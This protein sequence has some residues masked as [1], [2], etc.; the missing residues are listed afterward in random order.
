MPAC[1]RPGRELSMGRRS[2]ITHPVKGG[3]R[4][5]DAV[6]PRAI[7]L[8]G[9]I[10]FILSCGA[11]LPAIGAGF[12]D[13]DD[14]GFL[15][16]ATG[17]R[18]L[19]PE[20]LAWMATAMR[21]G[22]YQ[23]L[24]YLSYAIDYTFWGMDPR[25]YHT[26]NI[27][28]HAGNA[29]LLMFVLVRVLIL[30]GAERSRSLLFAAAAASI[31]WAVH[32]LRVESVA[33]I[34]ERRDVLSASFLL[35]SMLAYLRAV[36]PGEAPLASRR[37]YVWCLGLLLCSLLA[38][39]WGITFIAVV[40][41]LDVWPLR[42][43]PWRVWRWGAFA[44]V[45]RQKI[46]IA[47]LCAVFAF[48]AWMAQRTGHDETMRSFQDWGWAARGF[49]ACYGVVFYLWKT[50]APVDLVPLYELPLTF[51]AGEARW[52][53]AAGLV[54]V[55]AVAV[56][57]IARRHAGIGVAM[58]LYVILLSPVLGIA[59][60]GIQLVAD[61]YAYLAL[62]PI[63]G[64][65][66]AGLGRLWAAQPRPALL[67][68]T[69]VACILA[70]MVLGTLSWRQCGLWGDTLRLWETTIA[71]GHDGPVTRNYL[72]RQLERAGRYADAIREYEA[73][74]AFNPSY[75]DSWF[76]MGNALRSMGQHARAHE[77]FVKSIEVA[78]DP[79]RSQIALGLLRV[80]HLNDQAGAIEAF[81]QAVETAQRLGNPQRTGTPY[82]MLASAYGEAGDI[83]RAI[84]LLREAARWPDTREQAIGF[85][86]DLGVPP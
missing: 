59:Q 40:L 36:R 37:A 58:L 60:S 80:M 6:S 50:I 51:D 33:W 4:P 78:S 28:L 8:A 39:A 77:A 62:W 81:A 69:A 82:L 84:P 43:L 26:T 16:E 67:R 27:L 35:L 44:P 29:V 30:G 15:L 48:L 72:A 7:A 2:R 79:M 71:R 74:L 42:R 75:E 5:E 17:W 34:T 86:R 56:G 85:L 63:A 31:L 9:A 61:R 12:S 66:A 1:V 45:L 76:G 24:T 65:L 47:G 68:A 22:H 25:G 10:V 73:S 23:P 57:L 13:F 18:G 49:Q 52:W 54:I 11:F 70:A 3:Q 20:N 32:P 46:P 21:L 55:M 41:A 38:K 19:G 14:H 64:L 53:I 83:Q